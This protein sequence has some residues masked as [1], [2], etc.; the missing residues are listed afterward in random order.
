MDLRTDY[1]TVWL[2]VFK[3]MSMKMAV[4]WVV[5][6]CRLVQVYQRFGGLYCLHHQGDHHLGESVQ[7]SETS[8]ILH[9]STRRYN[10]E[11]SHVPNT[12]H[13]TTWSDI[14]LI[15]KLLFVHCA[16]FACCFLSYGPNIHLR[17]SFLALLYSLT[18]KDRA[19]HPCITTDKIPVFNILGMWI[20]DG[21]L[22]ILK[23]I[24]ASFPLIRSVLNP[25][26]NVILICSY[27]FKLF[28]IATFYKNF[29]VAFISKMCLSSRQLVKNFNNAI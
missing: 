13:L 4:S 26:V 17:S 7:T 29:L 16:P 22:K 18:V 28:I 10:P 1:N 15:M 19:S 20:E 8:V 24:R 2:Q 14:M 23:K 9:Q 11:E 21:R 25:F 3:A 6:P 12:K 27:F 5:A